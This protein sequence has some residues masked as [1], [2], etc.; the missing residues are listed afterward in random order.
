MVTDPSQ[1]V[2][3]FDDVSIGFEGKSVLKNVSL[4]V[5]PG[6]T[7]ILLGPA[8][9]GKSVLLKLANGLMKPDSGRAIQSTVAKCRSA[10]R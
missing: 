8:G 5:A 7:R 3:I 10:A 9:S 4:T 6:D 2:L 1:P